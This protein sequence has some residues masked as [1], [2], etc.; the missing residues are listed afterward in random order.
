MN[1]RWI[2][3]V[4][5]WSCRHSTLLVLVCVALGFA[6]SF[7]AAENF[8]MNSDTAS[9]ISPD[10]AWRKRQAAY[11]R[12][13]PQLDKLIL[14]VV[15][16]VTPERAD[17]AT[18]A[19]A[20]K[21]SAEKRYFESVRRSD[22]AF[23]HRNGLLFLSTAQ[24]KSTTEE[25]IKAQPFL[26]PLAADPTLHGVFAGLST[27]ILGV[28]KSQAKLSDLKRP[29]Q[30]FADA[31]SRVEAG[32]PAFVSWQTLVSG[33]KPGVRELRHFIMVKPKLLYD[34]LSP[35][36][37]ASTAIRNAARELHLTP[38][39]GVRVRLTGDIPLSDDEFAALA[40]HI[41]T[42]TTIM[43][44]GVLLVLWLAV[45]SVR[46]IAAILISLII[47]LA[48]TTAAGLAII[49][50][51]NLISVAFIPLCVGLGVDFGIQFAVRYRAERH[52]HETLTA[53]M[54][55]SGEGIGA[56]LTLAAAA[57]AAGFFAFLPTDYR[58]VAQL[59]LIAGIGMVVA[60]VLSFTLL[61]SLLCVLK[62]GEE[63]KEVG[64]RYLA[65][66]D[67]FIEKERTPVLL[68]AGILGLIGV[69]FLP[70]LRFDSNPLDMKDP[71]MESMSTLLDL[72][73]DRETTPNTIDILAPSLAAAKALAG[74]LDR[75]PEVNHTV[76]AAS[77][78]PD[79]QTEKLALIS[80][81]DM[82]L[83]PTFLTMGSA[84]P[85]TDAQTVQTLK[86]TASGLRSVARNGRDRVA[87]TALR[88]AGLL[89]R[90]AQ[91]GPRMRARASQAFVP[92]LKTTLQQ[93]EE[94]LQAAPVTLAS[95]PADLK[96]DWLT[97]DGRAR[98][99]VTPAGDSNNDANLKR[100]T[101]AVLRIAPHATGAPISIEEAGRT[102][103]NAFAEAAV[104]ALIV[105]TILLCIALRRFWGVTATLLPLIL[106][107]VLTL[108]TC[109]A[110]GLEIN[111]ANI[112]A[113]PL[114]LGVGVAFN[115]YFV[116]A[117]RRGQ[118]NLL[119][120]ALA[121]AVITS[122][123][124]TACGF[125]ILWLSDHR[126]MASM[127]ELLIIS[128]GWTLAVAL[129]FTPAL[130]IGLPRRRDIMP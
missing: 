110:I 101:A 115:I 33:E 88:L 117:W 45:R 67:R 1:A 50:T 96:R 12:A 2:G 49:G 65:P 15:D 56:A 53:G 113:L 72:M 75:L 98:V 9:L 16:G 93:M 87:A 129:F 30:T 70:F 7:Y 130:L 29:L 21:L 92:S 11:D 6:A 54:I 94:S 119:Q 25:I 39:N 118:G 3:R 43:M 109:A 124:T 62:P 14:V 8:S 44:I 105:I 4:V 81:A 64:F 60:Y 79:H 27:A 58:G 125:G 123:L 95:L 99:N 35:G 122:A 106:T 74:K 10:L 100:F 51:L 107:G 32:K 59:G 19:L 128:L 78:V 76:T 66:A 121:R 80:D 28:Q 24:V 36:R 77:F 111:F 108:G 69:V 126:G 38:D 97:R 83:E 90:L 71:N 40:N 13:F 116:M 61:P 103:V 73:K 127:G 120:S 112:I 63:Q 20:A 46:I 48:I 31:L 42:M 22:D 18:A 47:G 26:G 89:D 91:A 55:K 85:P 84:A 34:A 114:L 102:I 5:A 17:E 23:F 86:S 41:R 37:P 57:I 82:L 52:E 68:A 104:L